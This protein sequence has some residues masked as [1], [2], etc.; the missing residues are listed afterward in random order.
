MLSDDAA[1]DANAGVTPGSKSA[2]AQNNTLADTKEMKV[3]LNSRTLVKEATCRQI[4]K[5]FE[6]SGDGDGSGPAGGK[7]KSVNRGEDDK[8]EFVQLVEPLMQT[9]KS[10]NQELAALATSALVNLCNYSPDIKQIFETKDG[11][12]LILEFLKSNKE[13]ILLNVL[14]LIQIFIAGSEQY[15]KKIAEARDQESI[16]SLLQILHGP[17]IGGKVYT[18]RT[19]YFVV[20][21]LRQLIRYY[22]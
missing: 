16:N 10:D 6:H 5:L 12:T 8:V 4:I 20:I 3:D 2:A 17:G 9:M 1:D 18:T 19:Y 11:L 13:M 14:R 21:I 7:E 22:A 15:S